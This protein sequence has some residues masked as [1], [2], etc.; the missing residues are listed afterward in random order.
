MKWYLCYSEYSLMSVISSSTTRLTTLLQLNMNKIFQSI[1]I[2]LAAE[3]CVNLS[4]LLVLG[5]QVSFIHSLIHSTN[6]YWVSTMYWGYNIKWK[7]QES[8]SFQN[9]F[10]SSGNIFILFM[11][12]SWQG[13]WSDLS[14]PPPGD[15]GWDGWMVSPTQWT[16]IWANSGR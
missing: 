12:F 4:C 8:L 6:T 16:L 3:A 1:C 14:F 2:W 11:G 7:N 10:S 15:R 5:L 9:L 13:Y